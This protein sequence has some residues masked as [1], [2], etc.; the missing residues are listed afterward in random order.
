MA[1]HNINRLFLLWLGAIMSIAGNIAID[2]GH[3]NG[4]IATV[5]G[6]I[7]AIIGCD[8]WAHDKN[9]SWLFAL[10]GL[11][12]PIG[13]LVMASLKDKSN[14]QSNSNRY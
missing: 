8:L 1:K 7:I 12:A 13:Y 4:Q 11:A 10:W 9:R 2:T 14:Q 3:A 6:G 5:I